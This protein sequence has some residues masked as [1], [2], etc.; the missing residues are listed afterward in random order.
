MDNDT[1][2]GSPYLGWLAQTVIT[3]NILVLKHAPVLRKRGLGAR[4]LEEHVIE[5]DISTTL[6]L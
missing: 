1:Y 3:D 5:L 6:S 4:S 2:L